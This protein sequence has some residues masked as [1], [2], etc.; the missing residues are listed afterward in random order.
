MTDH[1][2]VVARSAK[3]SIPIADADFPVA[4]IPA[5]GTARSAKSRVS[6][7]LRTPDG[8]ELVADPA[9]KSLQ[10]ALDAAHAAP[11]GFWIAQG[12]LAVGGVLAEVGVVYQPPRVQSAAEA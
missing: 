2:D 10:K 12:R 5:K 11:G 1:I 6:L 7:R 8:I 9:T 4:S 3:V